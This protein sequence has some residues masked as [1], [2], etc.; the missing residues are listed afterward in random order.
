MCPP[1]VM[2]FLPFLHPFSL[3]ILTTFYYR[4]F[5]THTEA[6]GYRMTL[7]DPPLSSIVNNLPNSCQLSPDPSSHPQII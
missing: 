5:Y 6:G 7:T 2:Q 4:R 1:T 3:H